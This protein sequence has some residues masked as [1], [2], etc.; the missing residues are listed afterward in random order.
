MDANTANA[1]IAYGTWALA[2]LNLAL[3]GVTM[4][5]AKRQTAEAKRA[6]G[7]QLF[8]QLVR[9]YQD[10]SMRALRRK[11]ATRLLQARTFPHD[12]E[13]DPLTDE[14]VLEFFENLANLTRTSVLENTVVWSYFSVAID[15]YW[16]AVRDHVS[17]LRQQEG[18]EDWYREFENLSEDF[19]RMSAQRCGRHDPK[20]PS[21]E[22]VERYLRSE[23]N[24]A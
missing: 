20:R 13:V 11:F 14:S 18:E 2:L 10:P 23:T 5:A 3:V 9:E 22:T 1:L 21:P 7:L 19:A 24:L 12:P 16:H 17:A 4:S 15:G 6:T 8:A